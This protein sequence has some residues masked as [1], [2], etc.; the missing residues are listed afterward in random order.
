M[1]LLDSKNRDSLK[2][3]YLSFA[4]FLLTIGLLVPGPHF[5]VSFLR[6]SIARGQS[7]DF[8]GYNNPSL[9][10]NSCGRRVELTLEIYSTRSHA[11]VD[12]HVD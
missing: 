11:K 3:S 4:K 12:N 1:S 6:Y 8:G 10:Q 9:P 5:Y 2:E 7:V